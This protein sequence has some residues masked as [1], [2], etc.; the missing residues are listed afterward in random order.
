[1]LACHPLKVQTL[2]PLSEIVE[3]RTSATEFR[4]V[5]P[6]ELLSREPVKPD[7]VLIR[8][9]IEGRRVMVTG[10]GGSIGSALCSESLRHRPAIVVLFVVSEFALYSF[11]STAE[12]PVGKAYVSTRGYRWSR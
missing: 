7:L 5:T 4:E 1:M 12:R 10:A 8:R 9:E 2:P 11:E 3:G 6:E